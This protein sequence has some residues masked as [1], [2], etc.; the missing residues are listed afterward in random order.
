MGFAI[1]A[2]IVSEAIGQFS[3]TYALVK[4]QGRGIGTLFGPYDFGIA[5]CKAVMGKYGA[6][7]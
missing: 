2:D 3:I 4:R 7:T 6:K 5:W 1:F